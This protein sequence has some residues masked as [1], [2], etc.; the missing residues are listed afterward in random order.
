MQSVILNGKGFFNC[1]LANETECD[2]ASA[3][4]IFEQI[5]QRG[6]K[7]LLRLINTSTASTFIFSIDKHIMQVVGM[8]FVAIEPYYAESIL[9]GIGQR[10][11]VIVEAKPSNDLIPV[12][13]QNYWIRIVGARGCNPIEQPNEL[14]GI[15]RYNAGSEKT[16]VSRGYQFST[17]C[18]DE[19]YESLV[20]VVP[21]TVTAKDKPANDISWDGGDNYDVGIESGNATYTVPHGNFSRWDILDTPM[22][23]EFGN[24]TINHVHDQSFNPEEYAI[25][26]ENHAADD[27]VYLI[28]SASGRANQVAK[29][30][31]KFFAVAHPIHLHGHDF[32]ILSQ[33][34]R[35]YHPKDLTNGTF[36]YENPPRRDVA[37]L[38]SEGYIAIGFKTDNPG[39]WIIH[40]H[41]AWHASSGLALQIRERN[42]NVRLDPAFMH[43]KQRI[44]DN[45]NKWYD[46]KNNWYNPEEF[47]ED[48]GV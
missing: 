7:Y 1:S 33:Q 8:D 19:P 6:R 5:F 47:Q 36:N 20:P 4:K 12:E 15:V 34:N 21:R 13:D 14:L 25:I 29:K 24:P 48:S 41:I 18:S 30:N 45:W 22:W 9:I 39:I 11:H 17:D 16:P 42:R 38:P 40:C 31:K 26:T 27:W 35:P 44:C 23:L 28:I 10:Y 43:E 32:V 37:L 3:P 46:N 2:D